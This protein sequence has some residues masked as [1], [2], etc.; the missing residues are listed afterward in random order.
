MT[1]GERWLDRREKY[2]V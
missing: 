1:F 2:T